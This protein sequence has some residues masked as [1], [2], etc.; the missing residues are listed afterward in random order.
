LT[1]PRVSL[2]VPTW[3][4][5]RFVAETLATALAQ[6]LDGLEIVV[7]DDASQDATLELV[8]RCRDP[9]LRLL[10]SQRRLGIPGNWNR[11]LGQARAEYVLLLGQDDLLAPTALERLAAALDAAPEAPFAFARRE[12]RHEGREAWLPLLGSAYAGALE[13]FYASFRGRVTGLEMLEG[14]LSRGQ[15]P[16]VNLIGEPSFVLMR[17]EALRRS[18]GFDPG[19]RQLVD[20][21]LWLRLA[22][23]GAACFV[24]ESLG[25]FRVHAGGASAANHPR[26]RTRLEFL[27]I[28]ARIRRDYGQDL[29]PASR[30]QLAREEWR[31]RRHFVAGLLRLS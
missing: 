29:S 13:A 22:R 14:V 23:S 18:G 5:A 8:S 7:G 6:T 11:C 24:D 26:L 9:R 2:A 15:D 4:G 16:T 20:W 30:R 12:I 19:L 3:N 10:P 1:S 17:R 31:C 21:D 25:V 27:R 28:L